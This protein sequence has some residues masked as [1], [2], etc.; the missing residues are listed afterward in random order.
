MFTALVLSHKKCFILL[1]VLFF[2]LSIL[3]IIL[4]SRHLHTLEEDIH[5]FHPVLKEKL[6]PGDKCWKTEQFAVVEECDLCSGES[7]KYPTPYPTESG[8]WQHFENV[9][10]S[11]RSF[12]KGG[13]RI[14]CS[15]ILF[16]QI[17]KSSKS[18]FF[19]AWCE[20]DAEFIL[21][22]AWLGLINYSK[23]V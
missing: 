20:K 9:V 16:G 2:S 11:L 18:C 19:L 17:S 14:E 7:T 1:S 22:C 12:F 10:I 15:A 3:V 23:I 5:D 4:E 6:S 13:Q 8:F 21:Y